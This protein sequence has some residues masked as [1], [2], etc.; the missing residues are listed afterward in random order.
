V[1]LQRRLVGGVTGVN[2]WV[3][4]VTTPR[5]L[6]YGF[7]GRSRDLHEILSY[8]I[9]YRNRKCENFSKVVTFQKLKDFYIIK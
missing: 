1:P 5:N 6:G 2:P 4:F 9:I 3:G 7:A 8:P